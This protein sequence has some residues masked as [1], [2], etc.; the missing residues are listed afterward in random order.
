MIARFAILAALWLLAGSA[1][2]QLGGW[3]GT[4]AGVALGT[5][6][7]LWLD[8]R[9]GLR[10]NRWLAAPDAGPPP[11]TSGLWGEAAYRAAK[12][13]PAGE[14]KAQ[15]S[16][17]RMEEVLAAI[18]ASPNGVALL[19]AEGRI[20]WFNRT[21]SAHFGF[22]PG[23][24]LHQH[25]V[26]LVRD[27][28]FVGYFHAGAFEQPVQ[29]PARPPADARQ[30]PVRLSVQL[31]PY[32]QGRK[33]LL[34]YDVTATLLADAMRRDFVANV[35]HEIRTP[36]TVL[37][38]FV[39]T[40]QT[41]PLDERERERYLHLMAAQASRMQ[42]LVEDLLTL[43][44]LEGSPP[45]DESERIDL[46]ALMRQCEEQARALSAMLHPPEN[47]PQQIVFAPPPGF[48]LA[49]ATGEVSSA[50]SNLI[51]NAVRYTPAGGRID[52][53]WQRLPDGA[54]RLEVRDTGHGIAPEHL[55]RLAERFYRIDRSRSRES[56]GTGLGLA[57]VKHVAQRHGG[58]L[59]ITSQLG[60]GS[61]FALV[62]PARR[63]QA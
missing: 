16:A 7:A 12:A 37:T 47:K 45:P 15:E 38:G 53:G 28:A 60:R 55:P 13:L 23:R 9:R 59:Q 40:L 30:Q 19:D 44:R 61:C 46:A 26:N 56:G 52:V 22:Q 14:R 29:M 21:A 49:G 51:I 27:P 50:V 5:L 18:Q 41:L 62:F 17:Q 24:D 43:S 1:G 8:T 34:S 31:H 20:E 54:A 35:S 48:A 11:I 33:L 25:V 6:L 58:E 32:G 57:I 4:L 10:L 39:E 2:W 42:T 63:V 3:P 36:L